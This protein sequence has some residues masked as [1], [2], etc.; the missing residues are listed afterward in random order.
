V[1]YV[2]VAGSTTLRTAAAFVLVAVLA[3]CFWRPAVYTVLVIVMV[4]GFFRNLINSPEILLVKDVAL[5]S[6]YIRVLTVR[7]RRG[8]SLLPRGKMS[9]P[10]LAFTSVVLLECFN[11]HISNPLQ[12]LIGLRTWV[13]YLP[14]Y[15]VGIEMLGEVQDRTRIVTFLVI[16]SVP[17]CVLGVL[18]FIL[19]PA[20]YS[21]LGPGFNQATFVT[22][23]ESSGKAVFRPNATFS[24]PSH[25]ATFLGVVVLLCL[26]L[27]LSSRGWRLAWLTAVFGTLLAMNLIENQRLVI[28]LL[29]ALF[30]LVLLQRR[31]RSRLLAILAAGAV[32]LAVVQFAASQEAGQFAILERTLAFLGNNGNVV[33][34]RLDVYLTT[35]VDSALRAPLGLG[36]GTSTIG[37]RYVIGNDWQ[38]LVEFAW[39]KVV[40][41]LGVV[42][43]AVYFWLFA[44]L[45]RSTMRAGRAA[46]RAG[47]RESADF[48][49]AVVA[50]QVM[51]L[52][53]GY[54]LG[55]MAVAL[56]FLSGATGVSAGSPRP[57]DWTRADGP[58]SA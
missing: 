29:P 4:E 1:A 56:W 36:T 7:S 34:N 35:T 9:L 26:S 5:A 12:A 11:P 50:I 37:S 55:V 47:Q 44:T 23:I 46:A 18:Q 13:F 10:L 40:A 25:F 15:Y 22:A 14:L 20:A 28:A 24:F 49:A 30:V 31:A 54:E 48:A 58:D 3:F 38:L 16:A 6:I 51:A 33:N 32:A 2:L 27:M 52:V 43:L 21:H 53:T 45:I 17:A 8:E 19:G 42:G 39:A 41:D 57:H